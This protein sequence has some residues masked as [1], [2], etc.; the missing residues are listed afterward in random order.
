MVTTN[1][2][3]GVR[4]L[5]FDIGLVN[6]SPLH[7]DNCRFNQLIIFPKKKKIFLEFYRWIVYGVMNCFVRMAK[8][9]MVSETLFYPPLTRG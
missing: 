9:V 2:F 4:K 6:T 7:L 1:S 8:V 5:C 3:G